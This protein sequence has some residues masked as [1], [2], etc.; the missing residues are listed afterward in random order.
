MSKL[1]V[2]PWTQVR[3]IDGGVRISTPL[4]PHEAEAE[5]S[6]ILQ[7]LNAFAVPSEPGAV[8]AQFADV[9][10]HELAPVVAELHRIGVLIESDH[11]LGDRERAEGWH[12]DMWW[13]PHDA[14]FHSESRRAGVEHTNVL[15]GASPLPAVKPSM[16]D[17]ITPLSTEVGVPDH[18]YYDVLQYRASVREYGEGPI[19]LDTL[20]LLLGLAAQNTSG[21]SGVHGRAGEF[22]ARTYP[23]GG[24]CYSL[25]I[26][27]VI[28]D[29]AVAGLAAGVYHYC[30]H[31]HHLEALAIGP[32]DWQHFLHLARSAASTERQPPVLLLMTSRIGRVR[33]DYQRIAYSLVLKEVGALMQSLYLVATLLD[34]APC[35]LAAIDDSERLAAIGG[36]DPWEEPLVGEFVV[37][38]KRLG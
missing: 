5:G 12:G 3:W 30:P 38:P 14:L 6:G 27:P 18:A 16:S 1:V 20:S 31:H 25:E 28:G 2:S 4:S 9:A 21:P 17:Q 23:S 32:D 34:L 13:E 11:E 33:F 37:G 8:V 36:F 29:R 35:G 10:A 24:A 22:V 26:Y 15:P 7:L 19:S